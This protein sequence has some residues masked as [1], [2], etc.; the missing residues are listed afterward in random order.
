MLVGSKHDDNWLT[1]IYLSSFPFYF[2]A[3]FLRSPDNDIVLLSDCSL[4]D[5]PLQ[6]SNIYPP[7]A[8]FQVTIGKSSS[9][10]TDSVIHVLNK[11]SIRREKEV[12]LSLCTYRRLYRHQYLCC[13]ESSLEIRI[14]KVRISCEHN[15]N[16]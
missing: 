6:L 14:T 16:W 3:L 13:G 8:T 7:I 10:S 1:R 5:L 2:C 4:F 9:L 15:Q 12:R 11:K